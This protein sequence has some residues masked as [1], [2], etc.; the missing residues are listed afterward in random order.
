MPSGDLSDK[1]PAPDPE[2]GWTPRLRV[3]IIAG[4]MSDAAAPDSP[5]SGTIASA[6]AALAGGTTTAE[7][8]V[9]EALAR[10]ADPAGEGRRAFL[11]VQAEGLPITPVDY[12]RLTDSFAELLRGLAWRRRPATDEAS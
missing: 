3:R 1:L 12:H 7:A 5:P 9:E 10:I 8:L 11:D 4:M 6:S 2:P